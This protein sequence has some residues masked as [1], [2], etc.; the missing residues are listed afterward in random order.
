MKVKVQLIIENEGIEESITQEV[1][2][3][4]RGELLPESIGLTLEEGKALLSQIQESMVYHQVE[5]YVNQHRYCFNCGSEHSLKESN[6]ITFRTLFGKLKLDSPRLN[7]CFCE[8]QKKKSFSPLATRLPE[9]ISPELLYLEAKWPSLMSFGLTSDII[10]DILPIDINPSSLHHNAKKVAKRIENELDEEKWSYIEGCESEWEKL[11]HPDPPLT[12]GI[13]GGYVHARDGDNRKDGWFEVI[14]GKSMSE[15][16]DS[17]RFGFVSTYDKKPKRRLYEMLKNQGFQLNQQITFLSDGGDTVRELQ[18]YMS[19][20]AEHILDWFHVTM[21]ITTMKQMAKGLVSL[22]EFKDK[23]FEKDLDRVKWF[24][25]HGNVF[26]ALKVLD[27]ILFDI[28]WMEDE[29]ESYKLRK[30]IKA[31]DEYRGYIHNNQ[32]MIPN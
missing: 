23:D 31:V 21:R 19:P 6:K 8:P 27:N 7:T 5:G 1:A 32:E 30:F 4:T 26:K 10:N 22:D 15:K 14:I 16:V 11:P 20:W 25:W 3:L 13:D 2:C 17:K 29:T 18:Y 12:V 24:L 9:R 28:D